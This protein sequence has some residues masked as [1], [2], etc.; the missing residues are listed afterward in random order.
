M[1]KLQASK[2]SFEN[3]ILIAYEYNFKKMNSQQLSLLHKISAI[4]DSILILDDILDE[5]KTRN[6]KPCLYIKE[7][8]QKAIIS[9]ELL[10]I[11]AFN[12]ITKLSLISKTTKD[13]Q[14]KI[15]QKLNDFFKNI[16]LGQKIDLE[17]GLEEKYEDK[18]IKKYFKMI[19]L[20]TGG[21]IKFGLEIGQLI[22]N[23]KIDASLSK[24]ALSL[25]TIR[26]IY[27][28]FL[29]YFDKHHEAFGDFKNKTNRLP[30]LL[31]MKFDGKRKQVEKQ[32]KLHNYS[33]ARNLV[34][35]KQ[36]RK[37]LYNYCQIELNKC[38]KISTNFN[39]Q[40]LIEN[41]NQILSKQ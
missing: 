30:E 6:G 7:G 16:Y 34:L 2:T 3:Y 37:T 31:F 18:L 19:G 5:S 20:F 14:I 1:K 24:I 12:S 25:G 26:Q 17:L 32:L 41:F 27:D 11:E 8:L 4:D 33:S 38:Q 15:F 39:Y 23:K 40:N 36:V 13:N 10:R 29:D 22:A 21:H 9:A 35:N 28:D